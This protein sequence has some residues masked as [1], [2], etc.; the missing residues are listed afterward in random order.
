M[1]SGLEA[2]AALPYCTV[3]TS[4][5]WSE[6]LFCPWKKHGTCVCDAGLSVASKRAQLI[7]D[8]CCYRCASSG[9][10]ARSCQVKLTLSICHG[11]HASIM[12]DS[13]YKKKGAITEA[14]GST[15]VLVSSRSVRLCDKAPLNI[16]ARWTIQ[17]TCR[18]FT[19]LWLRTTGQGTPERLWVVAVRDHLLLNISLQYSHC[20]QWVKS[21][22][23]LTRFAT[24]PQALLVVGVSRRSQNSSDTHIAQGDVLC[25][26]CHDVAT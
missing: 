14:S 7:V 10:Q 24:H 13:N 11:K 22:F 25:V 21:E 8:N 4:S 5:S 16:I 9:H 17:F 20:R 15:T 12:C 1:L 18:L 19:S 26:I 2:A 23:Q 3:S 6:C